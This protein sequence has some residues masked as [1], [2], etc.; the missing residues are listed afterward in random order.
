MYP[1][2][3]EQIGSC[4][5]FFHSSFC[6]AHAVMIQLLLVASC[7][8]LANRLHPR[9]FPY[10]KGEGDHILERR[11][12]DGSSGWEVILRREKTKKMPV[13]AEKDAAVW[14]IG[15]WRRWESYISAAK[16]CVVFLLYLEWS[17][18]LQLS[19][20]LTGN[21]SVCERESYTFMTDCIYVIAWKLTSFV[22]V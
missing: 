3:V 21:S 1:F 10:G 16:E 15:N 19:C 22:I 9:G 6:Q 13:Y 2:V 20:I 14:L 18:V 8:F 5:C 17:E 11:G 7:H 12:A 4:S